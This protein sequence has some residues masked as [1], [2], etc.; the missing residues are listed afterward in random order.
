MPCFFDQMSWLLFFSLHVSVWLLFEGSYYLRAA[1]ISLRA[2]DC[3]ATIRGQCLFHLELLIV[4]LLFEGGVYLKKYSTYSFFMMAVFC[5]LPQYSRPVFST[6]YV[7]CLV[8]T[9]VLKQRRPPSLTPLFC[10]GIFFL[11]VNA[12]Q[13]ASSRHAF[14]KPLV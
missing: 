12:P 2:P 3:A 10:I 6:L 1:F 11:C 9:V 13:R 8:V 14:S 7:H 4:Q 5:S